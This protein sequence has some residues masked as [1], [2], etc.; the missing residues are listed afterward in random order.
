MAP[1]VT[2]HFTVLYTNII[3]DSI[4]IMLLSRNLRFLR[5]LRGANL[6]IVALSGNSGKRAP[7]AFSSVVHVP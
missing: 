5:N 3:I 1:I 6:L 4:V 7:R 2:L